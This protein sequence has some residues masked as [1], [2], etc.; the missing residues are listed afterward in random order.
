MTKKQY[1]KEYNRLW[2]LAMNSP[3]IQAI[4]CLKQCSKLKLR[5]HN[6]K[7]VGK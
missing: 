7:K 3:R 4:D 5:Y 2:N 1:L 6:S